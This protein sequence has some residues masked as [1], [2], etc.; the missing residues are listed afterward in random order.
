MKLYGLGYI[1]LTAADPAA[2]MPFWTDVVGLMPAKL[3]PGESYPTPFAPEPPA[4]AGTGVAP[5]GSTYLKMD[6][7]QWRIAVHPG[8]G[9]GLAY[10][11]FEV[12]DDVALDAAI[13]E[14]TAAGVDITRGTAE[15][16]A[17]RGVA[18]L[19]WCTDPCGHRVELFHGPMNDRNFV[20]P[21]QAEFKTG[22]LGLGHALMFVADID[23]C[24]RFYRGAL[25]FKRSDFI[26]LGPGMTAQFLRCTPRHHSVGLMQLGPMNMFNHLMLEVTSVD[27]VGA[28]LDR[29][30]AAG[31]KL[32]RTLG[33]HLND[34]MVS[35]Y[36]QSPAGFEVEIG[37]DGVM[38]DEATWRDRE[39]AGGEIWGHQRVMG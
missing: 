18:D 15:E 3:L 8:A 24:L 28:A 20:S 7:Y 34:R 2:M 35:F 17:A 1:G 9:P 6:D 27:M 33:R 14:V 16:A 22:E 31:V 39:A 23:A 21:T 30:T 36:M 38:V 4:S 29:A 37:W 32:T 5:D 10:L 26:N 11:G 13:A 12:A 25:G 19:A